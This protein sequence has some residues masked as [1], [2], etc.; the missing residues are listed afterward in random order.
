MLFW[1]THFQKSPTP[2]PAPPLGN[3]VPSLHPPPPPLTNPGYTTVTGVAI[4]G[5]KGP[6]QPPPPP[7]DWPERLKN[8][9]WRKKFPTIPQLGRFAPSLWP[10]VEKSWLCQSS[11]FVSIISEFSHNV[12]PGSCTVESLL[13]SRWQ[14]FQAAYASDH[15]VYVCSLHFPLS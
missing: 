13:I 14:I 15:I 12:W 6:M 8:K 4:R 11:S 1:Y 10:P 3:F 5:Y 2:Y 7:I 9:M